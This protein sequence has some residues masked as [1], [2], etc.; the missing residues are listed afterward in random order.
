MR[1]LGRESVAAHGLYRVLHLRFWICLHISVYTLRSCFRRRPTETA[2]SFIPC[3]SN[4][5]AARKLREVAASELG[6]AVGPSS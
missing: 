5:A 3:V 4:P 2:I 1:R 6:F